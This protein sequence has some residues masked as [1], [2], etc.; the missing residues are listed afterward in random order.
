MF[1]KKKKV[2]SYFYWSL[3]E[4]YRNDSGISKQRIV[5]NL[6]NTKKAIDTLGSEPQYKEFLEK[7]LSI[8]GQHK[9]PVVPNSILLG[10]NIYRLK[11]IPDQTFNMCVTSP[12]Y[13]GLRDYGSAGQIGMEQSLEE[14]IENLIFVFREVKRVLKD[15]GTLWLNLGDCYSGSSRGR[16]SNGEANPGKFSISKQSKGQTIGNIKIP[17]N[18]QGLKNKDLIGLPWRVA[19]ALQQDGW[20]LR[21][22]I[23]WNKP[24]AMPESVRDRPTRSH[25][26]IFLLSKSPTYYYDYESI[27]EPAVNGDPNS[28]RGSNG[29]IGEKNKGIRTDK[30]RGSFKGK[31]GESAFRAIRKTRNKRTVWTVTTKPIKEAH[32]ASFP[33]DLIEPCIIAGS[34]E[35]GLVLDPF[36]GS[37]TTGIAALKNNRNFIGIEVNSDYIEIAKSR[38]SKMQIAADL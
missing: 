23:I 25:E 22:E 24:N 28:P 7:L 2:N 15:D 14:Y 27:K 21:T 37:G 32:F 33:P 9:Q 26:Y 8:V 17:R 11:E 30:P 19:F 4:S 29:V 18:I 38:L 36:F 35:N 34:P 1:L 16:N 13:W 3:A 6:G 31:Y 12:P 5:K 10:N 20:Y